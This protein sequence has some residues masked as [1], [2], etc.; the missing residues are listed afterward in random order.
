MALNLIK[1]ISGKELIKKAREVS[2]LNLREVKPYSNARISFKEFNPESGEAKPPT[3]YLL[4]PQIEW[5]KKLRNIFLKEHE[6][7]VLKLKEALV[8]EINEQKFTLLPVIVEFSEADN[9]AVIADGAHRAFLARTLNKS[10][11]ALYV[12]NADKEYPYYALPNEWSEVS[13]HEDLSTV[14]RKKNYRHENKEELYK[15]YRDYNILG[16]GLISAPR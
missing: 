16:E 12:E 6:I 14:S 9:Q 5:A 1:R 7:D 2:L 3:L 15:L 4:K 10:F 13:L 11:S 8:Y